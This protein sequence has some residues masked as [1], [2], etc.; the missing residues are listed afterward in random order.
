MLWWLE[1]QL[2]QARIE[3]WLNHDLFH[4]QWF[5]LT[6][7]L[8]IPWIIWWRYVDRKRLLEILLFG[9]MIFITASYLDAVLSELGLWEYHYWVVPLWPRFIPADFTVLPILYMLLYQRFSD[10]KSFIS[11]SIVLAALLAF[12]GESFL[13]WADIYKQHYWRHYYSF[14]IYF[15]MGIFIRGLVRSLTVIQQR[16]NESLEGF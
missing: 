4:W 14:P 3:N 13:I 5:L 10:W 8:I 11:A 7:F 1:K 16:K 2:T 9:A 15:A 6:A 12:A